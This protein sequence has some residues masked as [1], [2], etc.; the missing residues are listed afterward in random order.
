MALLCLASG[1]GGK[2]LSAPYNKTLWKLEQPAAVHLRCLGHCQK[3]C[4]PFKHENLGLLSATTFA[5][6][7][8]V[9]ARNTGQRHRGCVSVKAAHRTGCVGKTLGSTVVVSSLDVEANTFE[10]VFLFVNE[11]LL[12]SGCEFAEVIFFLSWPTAFS[13]KQSLNSIRVGQLHLFLI[14]CMAQVSV[15]LGGSYC[16]SRSRKIALV[17]SWTKWSDRKIPTIAE[18]VAEWTMIFWLLYNFCAWTWLNWCK[19]EL[20]IARGWPDLHSSV[21][22]A[23]WYIVP[24]YANSAM[25][26]FALPVTSVFKYVNLTSFVS[27]A[28]S[29]AL[30]IWPNHSCNWWGLPLYRNS[31]HSGGWSFFDAPNSSARFWTGILAEA[32]GAASPIVGINGRA[33]ILNG[34]CWREVLTI[35]VEYG[36][37]VLKDGVQ[38]KTVPLLSKGTTGSFDLPNM[39]LATTGIVNA[40]EVTI[41]CSMTRGDDSCETSSEKI[42]FHGSCLW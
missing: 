20:T 23:S 39:P 32:T 19:L 27:V 10:A 29:I 12:S 5:L 1:W 14:V 35:P 22:N 24:Q 17:E 31:F 26:V 6:C 34:L 3:E 8:G 13:S 11:G 36:G 16:T 37:A 40:W 21:R 4:C 7:V 9:L 28:E 2:T 33:L 18:I 42:V 15:K 38:K 41:G 25:A 30:L